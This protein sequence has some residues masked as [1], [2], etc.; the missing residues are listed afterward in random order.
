MT[1]TMRGRLCWTVL[2][3]ATMT[4]SVAMAQADGPLRKLAPGVLQTVDPQRQLNESFSRHDLVEL[5]A[6]NPQFDWAKDVPIRHNIWTLEF[7]FKPMR[8]VWVDIPQPSGQMQR[9]LIWYLLY[10]VTNTGQALV[11]KEDKDVG[12]ET[13]L[14]RK[15][16][17][18]TK[19]DAPVRFIP[20]FLLEAR[21]RLAD[22]EGTVKA[23]RDNIIPVAIAPIQ[24]REDRNLKLLNTVEICGEIKLGETRW[25]VATW[26]GVDPTTVRFSV[27]VQGLT[28]AYRW[29][30]VEGAVK[31][32]SPIGTGRRLMRK[33][34]VLNFWR[35][36]DEFE[37]NE[38][39]IRYGRP[40]AV[41]YEW[42]YR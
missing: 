30:D 41:D 8:M 19:V 37:E 27:H 5:L 34:L 12:Y 25:G 42:V 1:R 29:E 13:A 33:T 10:S 32:G 14:N 2:I 40:G 23:Y 3:F 31:V 26:Q 38:D 9:Q 24:A 22:G 15:V 7:K 6:V 16:W 18:V 35:P 20:N 17:E 28:N 11:P 39:E 21:N 36:G 4:A